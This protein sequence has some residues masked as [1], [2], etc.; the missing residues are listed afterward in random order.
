LF[1][2]QQNILLLQVVAEEEVVL[3]LEAG[4]RVAYFTAQQ[5]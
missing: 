2:I 5:I 4:E 1:L 3:A